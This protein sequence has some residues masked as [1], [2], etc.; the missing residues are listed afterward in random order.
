MYISASDYLHF[1]SDHIHPTRVCECATLSYI[2]MVIVISYLDIDG[3]DEGRVIYTF[4]RW[5][6]LKVNCQQLNSP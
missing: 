3:V 6:N 5:R 1:A 2:L 4:T